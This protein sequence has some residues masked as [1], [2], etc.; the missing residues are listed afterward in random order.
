MY[1]RPCA[2]YWESGVKRIDKIL[3]S[4]EFTFY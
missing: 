2:K 1:A 4:T 3:A